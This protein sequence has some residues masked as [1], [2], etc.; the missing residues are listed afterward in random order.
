VLRLDRPEAAASMVNDPDAV[1]ASCDPLTVID[2]WPLSPAVLGAVKRN[3]DANSGAGRFL[4]AGSSRADLQQDGWPATGR[5][6]RVPMWPMS[7]HTGLRPFVL[8]ERI[9]ALPIS[10]IWS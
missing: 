8:D 1:L 10:T 5:V 2:E 6:L 9:W 3:V 4:L 7:F